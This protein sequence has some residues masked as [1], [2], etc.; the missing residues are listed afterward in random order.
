MQ[1]LF[2]VFPQKSSKT[3]TPNCYKLFCE[4]KNP[5][6]FL[7]TMKS[8][9]KV[10]GIRYSVSPCLIK[11]HTTTILHRLFSPPS[12]RSSSQTRISS[13]HSLGYACANWQARKHFLSNE[14]NEWAI[15]FQS[16]SQTTRVV[17]FTQL[18]L[19]NIRHKFH[20]THRN[21][22]DQTQS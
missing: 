10:T 2:S 11:F 9:P 5:S 4:Q 19:I 18:K 17:I 20:K 21:S 12:H 8:T 3:I 22:K 1:V 7:V 14:C 13:G 6:G 16:N 15:A